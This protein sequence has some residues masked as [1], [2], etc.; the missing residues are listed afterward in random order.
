MGALDGKIAVITGGSGGI[1]RAT[2]L[3]LAAEDADVGVG[4][5]LVFLVPPSTRYTASA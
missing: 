2:A 3:A 1:G 5:A 4:F